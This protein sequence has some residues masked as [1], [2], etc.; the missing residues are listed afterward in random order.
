M[1][2]REYQLQAKEL[3]QR[4]YPGEEVEEQWCPFR[5]EGQGMY[6]PRVDLAVGPF[7]TTGRFEERY[8]ELLDASRAFVECLVAKH[9]ENIERAAA[10]RSVL[11]NADLRR[12]LL[13]GITSFETIAFFNENARCL[14]C[15]EIEETGSRKHCLGDLVNASALGRVGLLVARAE[16]VM[17]VFLRQ[18]V[19]LQFLASVGKNTFKTDNALVL[20]AE[21]FDGCLGLVKEQTP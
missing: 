11:G 21:Q 12:L 2:E 13:S 20:S 5:G 1:D 7:A 8:R 14:L 9:N 4:I 6:C 17:R 16:K 19:Y 10:H 18:R 3:L 15:I